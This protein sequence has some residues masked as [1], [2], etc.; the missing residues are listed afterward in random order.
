MDSVACSDGHQGKG[1]SVPMRQTK[2]IRIL[3]GCCGL[4]LLGPACL[5][6]PSE[7]VQFQVPRGGFPDFLDTPWPSDLLLRRTGDASRLD[8]GAFPNPSGVA[9]LE[10]YVAVIQN[11]PGY[12]SSG[13]LY[14]RVEGGVSPDT[15]PSDAFASTADDASMFLVAL[16][17]P[18]TKIPIRWRYYAAGTS[19]LPAGTVAAAP[20][21]GYV[22][23]GPAAL[24]VTRFVQHA[25]GRR[26]GPSVDMLALLKCG[27][28]ENVEVQPDCAPYATLLNALELDAEDVALMQIFTPFDATIGLRKA[29]EFL[30][31]QAPPEPMVTERVPGGLY[32]LYTQYRG[33]VALAQFQAGTP[34]F[35]TNDG[36]TGA[37]VFDDDGVPIVQRSEQVRFVLT[38]PA[39]PMPENGW[40]IAINGHGTGGDLSTGLGMDD[41]AEAYQ[42][43][44]AGWAMLA[45]SEPLHATREGH[46]A[47]EEEILTFNFLNP[48]AGRDNWRQSALEKVQLVSMMTNLKVGAALTGDSEIRFDVERIGYF[49]HSQG[50]ITGS[51]FLGVEDRIGGA[52]LS[53][54]GGGFATSLVDKTMPVNIGEVLRTFLQMPAEEP[55]DVFHPVLAL[56]QTWIEPA[57]PM[58]YGALWRHRDD[59]YTPHLLMTSGLQDEYTPPAT[60]AGFAG[61][62]ELPPIVGEPSVEV[63][64]LKALTPIPLGSVGNLQSASGEILSAGVLQFPDDGHFAVY[65]N[66]AAKR[67]FRLFFDTLKDGSPALGKP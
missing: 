3:L 44:A 18:S 15:L 43:A 57:E 2:F 48:M 40:P 38:V 13:P 45:I 4:F 67:A 30:R 46:R 54:A 27:E 62:F 47:G 65:R 21:L 29:F 60:H 7:P 35:T 41:S 1:A 66:P 20:V 33:E 23:P 8:L 36:V 24:V 22:V 39:G 51:L 32:D 61:A 55:L 14:F 42:L 6:E 34:P 59:R 52:F 10:D 53:G 28:I 64:D 5:L 58:N 12:S 63:L 11:A 37:F 16:D 25:N 19:F 26:L 50:A 49:G 56:L 17:A 31:S 9:F